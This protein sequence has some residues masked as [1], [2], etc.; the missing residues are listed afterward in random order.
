MFSTLSF[1]SKWKQWYRLLAVSQRIWAVGFRAKAHGAAFE[2][3]GRRPVNMV[4]N[5]ALQGMARDAY[6]ILFLAQSPRLDATLTNR[7]WHR[8]GQPGSYL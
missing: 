3:L 7:F 6:E 8:C 1:I 5:A 4:F 2:F